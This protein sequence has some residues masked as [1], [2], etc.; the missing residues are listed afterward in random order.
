MT[1]TG[2]LKKMETILLN[3]L[4]YYRVPQFPSLAGA[5]PVAVHRTPTPI[6]PREYNILVSIII[7]KS[8]IFRRALLA[9]RKPGAVP[10]LLS[11]LQKIFGLFLQ[12]T[13]E[14]SWNWT[15]PF[16]T[17]LFKAFLGVPMLFAKVCL[18]I[19]NLSVP[20]F[21]ITKSYVCSLFQT[22]TSPDFLRKKGTEGW[23]L[24]QTLP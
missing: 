4:P 19:T 15:T 8:Y 2:L 20:A 10:G 13:W 17:I 3:D 14:A 9:S 22:G 12:M 5:F 16:L 23:V 21:S 6:P 11:F 24:L 7:G 1:T 18:G